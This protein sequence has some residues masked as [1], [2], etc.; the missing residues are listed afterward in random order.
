M[1]T[2]FK[3]VSVTLKLKI[4]DLHLTVLKLIFACIFKW[5]SINFHELWQ[6]KFIVLRFHYSPLQM[7]L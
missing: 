6:F 3:V 1:K 4:L 7:I 2:S 5:S